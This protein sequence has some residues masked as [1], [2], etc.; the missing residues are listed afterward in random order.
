MLPLDVYLEHEN[1]IVDK[2]EGGVADG[3]EGTVG[4][5]FLMKD[6]KSRVVV[7]FHGVSTRSSILT[8]NPRFPAW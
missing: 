5:R 8:S 4:A 3:L 6:T 7:N 2:S 1:E